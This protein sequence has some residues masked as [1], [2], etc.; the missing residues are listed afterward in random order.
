MSQCPRTWPADFVIFRSDL[1]KGMDNGILAFLSPISCLQFRSHRST[2]P[3]RR[4]SRLHPAVMSGR[5]DSHRLGAAHCIFPRLF[6][7]VLLSPTK[8]R[9]DYPL[10]KS[11]FLLS[12]F[13]AHMLIEQEISHV[14]LTLDNCPSSRSIL[15]SP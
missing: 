9:F 14:Q 4:L 10:S 2:H 5:K 15:P 11:V 13:Q 6:G 12:V 7:H 8:I 3:F 1:R